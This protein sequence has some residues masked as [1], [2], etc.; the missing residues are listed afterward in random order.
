MRK[1]TVW[2]TIY[3]AATD[4]L[5][6][7]GTTRDCARILD[8]TPASVQ[9]IISRVRHGKDKT[10]TIVKEDLSKGTYEVYGAGN[11]QKER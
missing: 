7:C 8:M 2:Y 4:D 5:L 3:D 11:G 6:A 1:V 9:S 10:R